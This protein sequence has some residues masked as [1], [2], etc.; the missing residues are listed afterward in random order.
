MKYKVLVTPE[1]KQDLKVAAIWYNKQRKGLGK[2]FL[3]SIREA[4]KTLQR[5]PFFAIRYKN[6]HTLPLKK[7]P[8][9]IHFVIEKE[10]KSVTILA[11]LHTSMNPDKWG[12]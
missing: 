8:F 1:A 12:K 10:S 4:L 3:S 7:F 9:M 6:V 2:I 11:A 5:N